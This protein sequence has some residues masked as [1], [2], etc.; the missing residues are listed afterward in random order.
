MSRRR[1]DNTMSRR[2]RTN[3]RV[4]MFTDPVICHE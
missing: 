2:R 1:T 3:R 4:T